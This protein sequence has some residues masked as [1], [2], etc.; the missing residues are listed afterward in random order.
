M[1]KEHLQLIEGGGTTSPV[2]PIEEVERILT[3][4]S[5][6]ARRSL[7][8]AFEEVGH[9]HKGYKDG[10]LDCEEARDIMERNAR[11]FKRNAGLAKVAGLTSDNL[12]N[13]G[14]V[15][16]IHPTVAKEYDRQNEQL[17]KEP[18][19]VHRSLFSTA[20]NL[21]MRRER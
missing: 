17:K 20:L 3:T 12:Y 15:I 2:T 5:E 21:V 14:G 9:A 19:K 11:Y 1:S 7:N 10:H 8:D 13:S 16:Y 6:I 4:H 18:Q